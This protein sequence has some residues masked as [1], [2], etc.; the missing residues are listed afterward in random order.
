MAITFPTNPVTNQTFSVNTRT[1]KWNGV[2][3]DAILEISGGGGGSGLEFIAVKDG[4]SVPEPQSIT[5]ESLT[6]ILQIAASE[7]STNDALISFG[8]TGD[9]GTELTHNIEREHFFPVNVDDRNGSGQKFLTLNDDGTVGFKYILFQDVFKPTEFQF[10]IGDFLINGSSQRSTLIGPSSSNFTLTSLSGSDQFTIQYPSVTVETVSAE[11][12]GPFLS[13][14]P[15]TL[16]DPYTSLSTSGLQVQYPAITTGDPTVTFTVNGEG[17]DGNTDT[18]QCSIIFPNN[19]YYGVAGTESVDGSNLDSLLTVRLTRLTELDAGLTI[20]VDSGTGQSVF[21]AY[22]KRHGTIVK[23]VDPDSGQD[24]TDIFPLYDTV[25]H[26]NSNSYT[27][28]Y[29]IYRSSQENV[30]EETLRFT[31]A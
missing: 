8:I 7:P 5:V 30:G 24:K 29:Y 18:A 11:I 13:G 15:I 19:A 20:Q 31:T 28:D 22:P 21:F 4:Y 10:T 25:S 9:S 26:T 17:S 2:A 3:W 1:W 16:S 14:S 27:E 6:D 23:V 12:S